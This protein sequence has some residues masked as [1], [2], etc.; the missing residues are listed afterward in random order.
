MP[1]SQQAVQLKHCLLGL[2]KK[3]MLVMLL[4]D[5][6]EVRARSESAGYSEVLDKRKLIAAGEWTIHECGWLPEE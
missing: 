3:P 1:K 4:T 6:F 2:K 5:D